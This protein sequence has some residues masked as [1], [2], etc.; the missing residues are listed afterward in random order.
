VKGRRVR[1][2]WRPGQESVI[3]ESEGGSE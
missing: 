3:D 1:V 2:E